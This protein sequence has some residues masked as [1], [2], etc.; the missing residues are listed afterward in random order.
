MTDRETVLILQQLLDGE[1]VGLR[2]RNRPQRHVHHS[3]G[4]NYIWHIDGYD[5]LKPF[6]IAT[7]GC[8]NRFSGKMIWPEAYKTNTGPH[9]RNAHTNR[10]VLKWCVRVI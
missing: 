6:E 9:A 7:S 1:G 2:S 3:C 8:I 4:P 10:C 5:R